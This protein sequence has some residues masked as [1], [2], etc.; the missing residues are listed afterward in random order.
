MTMVVCPERQAFIDFFIHDQPGRHIYLQVSESSYQDHSSKLSGSSVNDV[1]LKYRESAQGSLGNDSLYVYL[2]TSKNLMVYNQHTGV[3]ASKHF[4]QNVWLVS[5]H[6]GHASE[7][8]NRL[9]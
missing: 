5:N 6:E 7:F 2:T 8:L 4:D 1:V 9:L 3:P